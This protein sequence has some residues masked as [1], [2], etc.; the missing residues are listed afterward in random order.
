LDGRRLTAAALS[1]NAQRPT[2]PTP[3]SFA[4]ARNSGKESYLKKRGE[5]V[6]KCL[7]EEYGREFFFHFVEQAGPSIFHHLNLKIVGS[8][9]KG[10]CAL[11]HPFNFS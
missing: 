1:Q 5:K 4:D 2:R 10:K 9:P 11:T 8:N 7:T 6:R 3:V